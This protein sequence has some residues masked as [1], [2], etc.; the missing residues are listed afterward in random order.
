MRVLVE[1]SLR[2][3]VI[4]AAILIVLRAFQVKSPAVLHRAWT[5]VLAAMLLLPAFAWWAP[6]VALPVLPPA[7]APARAVIDVPPRADGM[8]WPGELDPGPASA[9][10]VIAAA[11]SPPGRTGISLGARQ[12][13]SPC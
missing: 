7:P 4:A 8:P 6:T 3:A 1:S 13:R 9:V 12:T 2:A 11:G 5:C 10:S